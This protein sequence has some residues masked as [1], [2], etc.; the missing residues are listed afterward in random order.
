MNDVD[1][2]SEQPDGHRI[3]QIIVILLKYVFGAPATAT[4]AELFKVLEGI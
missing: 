3:K 4:L 2:R 1:W